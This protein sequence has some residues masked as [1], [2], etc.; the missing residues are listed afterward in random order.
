VGGP[1]SRK[2]WRWII[3]S[4]VIVLAGLVLIFLRWR[5]E[6]FDWSTFATVFSHLKWLWVLI[7][8][9]FALASYFGRALRWAVLIRPLRPDPSIW[10]L[11]SATAIGF[12]AVVIFGRPGEFVRP[13]LIAIKERVPFSSQLAAWL[14]ERI[15]DLLSALLIFGFALAQIEKSGMRI[16]PRLEWVLKTGGH[17]AWIT[18]LICLIILVALQAY[19]DVMQRRLLDGMSFLPKGYYQKAEHL[20]TSF[21]QGAKA[22]KEW[23]A[24]V[25]VIL[26]TVLEWGL[27]VAC[28]FSLFRAFPELAHFR[29]T[30]V[31]IVLG[32]VAFGSVVQIPGVG[33]GMQIVCIFVLTEMFRMPLEVASGVAVVVWIITFVVIVPFGLLLLFREGLNWQKL[34]QMEAEASV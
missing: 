2:H 9:A 20:I 7:A 16:G 6:G 31:M 15:Y 21:V 1:I 5:H 8:V 17:M 18:C 25:K 24:L 26:Y 27:I 13:Y 29:I 22:T 32:F 34:K 12:T 30:D 33:G 10:R 11:F 28:Y 4:L 3:T 19:S 23:P 14:L